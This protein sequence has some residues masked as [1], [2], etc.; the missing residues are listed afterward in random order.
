MMRNR[1]FGL[2]N[3]I[4]D[5]SV[6]K[7]LSGF[8]IGL[9]VLPVLKILQNL[10]KSAYTKCLD[11]CSC[12]LRKK[13]RAESTSTEYKLVLCVRSDLAMGKGKIGA[14]CGHASIGAYLSAV[15]TKSPYLEHWLSDGQR[16]V[17]LKIQDYEEMKALRK[18]AKRLNLNTHVT[19]DAGRTQVPSGSYTVIAIGPG[20]EDLLNKITG[21]LKLL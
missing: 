19:C 21:H 11:A 4:Y 3:F 18:E 8:V 1:T 13:R 15:E 10:S 16:K 2:M 17:V 12:V 5:E 14:Q 7:S 9:L 6:R 20:P